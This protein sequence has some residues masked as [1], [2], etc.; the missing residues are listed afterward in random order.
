MDI[1]AFR[2]TPVCLNI[3]LLS[4]ARVSAFVGYPT[5]FVKTPMCY[6]YTFFFGDLQK[7]RSVVSPEENAGKRQKEM[8]VSGKCFV[9]LVHGT[10]C[11]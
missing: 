10:Q 2:E 8:P 9:V 3:I 7:L 11:S 4:A 6:F 1:S 5:A